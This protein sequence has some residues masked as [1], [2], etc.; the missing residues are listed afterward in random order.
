VL[1]PNEEHLLRRL[2]DLLNI[3]HRDFIASKLQVQ[4]A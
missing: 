4:N 1:D 2:A 3:P